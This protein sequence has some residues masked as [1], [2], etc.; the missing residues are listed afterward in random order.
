MKNIDINTLS[1]EE[2]IKL[3]K[4]QDRALVS[5]DKKIL[6]LE[7]KTLKWQTKYNE[8]MILLENKMFIIKRDNVNKY[9]GTK[10]NLEPIQINEAEA[11]KT[12]GRK[13]GSK[14]F[15]SLDL[16]KTRIESYDK[17]HRSKSL[18]QLWR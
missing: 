14:N 2:L 10:E 7:K 11:K 6:R 17:R 1:K 12:P 4:R 15:E 8:A 18:R 3:I 5:K 16:E 13:K 9:V